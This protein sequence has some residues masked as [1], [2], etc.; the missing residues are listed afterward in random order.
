MTRPL[1]VLM[2]EDNP[3]DVELALYELKK[4]GFD[5]TVRAVST[6]AALIKELDAFDPE[7]ILGDFTLPQFD[8]ISALQI[9]HSKRPEIPFIFVSGTIGEDRAIETLENGAADYILKM[10]LKRLA[11]A[12][13]RALHD[14]RERHAR[15]QL[16][17][18][19]RFLAQHDPLTELP[20]R[21]Q[22][23][24]LLDGALA[25]AARNGQQVGLMILN[26]DRFQ[27]VNARFGHV[28]ADNV[29]RQAAERIREGARKGDTIARLG[30]DEFAVLLEGTID[31]GTVSALA[32]RHRD[33]L[34]RPIV[35]GDQEIRL[36]ASIGVSLVPHDT[37]DV[38]RLLR[39]ADVAMYRAKELG[40]NNCQCYSEEL[41][42]LTR[43]DEIRHAEVAQ[44]LARLT[45]RENQVLDGLIGGKSSKMIAYLLGASTRTV[46]T[47]RARIMEKMAADSVADL[48]RTVLEHRK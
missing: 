2:V 45:P 1:R 43:R 34:A 44:R 47:H 19:L 5:C 13:R 15:A 26:L 35:V 3:S 37:R 48:V 24:E 16:E 33:E 39:N 14:A 36:T 12:V 21:S 28:A 38:D 20:N 46:E 17:S 29:L 31:T 10:N 9:A 30:A 40:R 22:F 41:D 25:R 4:A 6:R 23:R 11:P 8:G 42:A 32:Q 7:L 18:R 27:N